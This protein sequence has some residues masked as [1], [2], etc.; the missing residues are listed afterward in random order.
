MKRFSILQPASFESVC[1]AEKQNKNHF[2]RGKSLPEVITKRGNLNPAYTPLNCN[3]CSPL[4]HVSCYPQAWKH[5]QR[6]QRSSVLHSRKIKR[7][8]HAVINLVAESERRRTVCFKLDS[9]DTTCVSSFAGCAQGRML[10][11]RT[12]KQLLFD[13][14]DLLLKAPTATLALELLA[15]KK[16]HRCGN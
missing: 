14:D 1:I 5:S 13:Q 11:F 9:P 4:H 10:N 16:R 2:A 15:R 6:S 7:S 3:V 12:Q 8:N